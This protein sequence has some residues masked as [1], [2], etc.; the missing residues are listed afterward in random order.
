MELLKR[1]TILIA[2]FKDSGLAIFT[3]HVKSFG[4]MA[5]ALMN[6]VTDLKS[7]FW[8]SV[9]NSRKKRLVETRERGSSPAYNKRFARKSIKLT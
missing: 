6:R 4:Q 9:D 1:N 5:I 2:N 8:A 7:Y 3:F